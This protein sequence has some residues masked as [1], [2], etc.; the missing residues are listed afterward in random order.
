MGVCK[1]IVKAVHPSV[2]HLYQLIPCRGLWGIL[3]HLT[4]GLPS[5]QW[6]R[7]TLSP[8]KRCDGMVPVCLKNIEQSNRKLHKECMTAMLCNIL[9]NKVMTHTANIKRIRRSIFPHMDQPGERTKA[10][11]LTINLS[12]VLASNEADRREP[13][14]FLLWDNSVNHLNKL[15]V[16]QKTGELKTYKLCLTTKEPS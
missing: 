3:D 1:I 10:G 4:Q 7:P 16:F 15:N 14:T 9:Q 6:N 8:D 2:H 5:I 13:A 11:K 12:V